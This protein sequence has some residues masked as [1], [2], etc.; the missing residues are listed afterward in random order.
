MKKIRKINLRSAYETLARAGDSYQNKSMTFSEY[1]SLVKE[2][3]VSIH[4]GVLYDVMNKKSIGFIEL[5]KD[6][7]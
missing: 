2:I 5:P 3:V 4:N 7:K 1:H 6:R